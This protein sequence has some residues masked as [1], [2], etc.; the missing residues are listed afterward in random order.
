MVNLKEKSP[1]E[2]LALYTLILEEL[3]SREIIR[4]SNA[5]TGDYAEYLF[6]NAFEWEQQGNS[7]AGYDAIS[8]DGIRYQIKSRRL[9]KHN[10][11]R[12]L[13]FIRRLEAKQFD[14]LAGVLFN[15]DFSVWKAAIIPHKLIQPRSRFAKTPNGWLF[16]LEDNVWAL[17]DVIDVTNE[18]KLFERNM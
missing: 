13:S 14:Y 12:Q 1:G 11:S 15:E 7:N 17:K 5:P 18:L 3:R 8:N 16:K 9:T 2:L 6:C 10:A 4:S